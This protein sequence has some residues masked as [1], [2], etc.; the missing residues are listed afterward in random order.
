MPTVR[1]IW[2]KAN[3]EL[4]PTNKAGMERVLNGNGNFAFLMEQKSIEYY[5]GKNCQLTQIGD[6]LNERNYAIALP[7]SNKIVF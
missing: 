3:R 1:R 7:K 6:L 2:Q 5:T 4:K